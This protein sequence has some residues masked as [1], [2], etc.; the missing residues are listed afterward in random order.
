MK[1]FKKK[2]TEKDLVSFGNF[3]LSEREI[4]K[5]ISHADLENWKEL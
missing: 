3:I 4:K 5:E 1:L 2:Y